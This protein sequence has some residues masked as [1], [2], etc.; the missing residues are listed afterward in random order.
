LQVED[1]DAAKQ[2]SVAFPT[3]RAFALHRAPRRRYGWLDCPFASALADPVLGG[4]QGASLLGQTIARAAAVI[5]FTDTFRLVAVLALVA[6][7]FVVINI[8]IVG[9]TARVTRLTSNR[10]M[11][12]AVCFRPSCRWPS[13]AA[14]A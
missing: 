7:A 8:T 2:G 1:P 12:S 6:A 14:T 11:P 5:A 3:E 13:P 10:S 4:A 9:G